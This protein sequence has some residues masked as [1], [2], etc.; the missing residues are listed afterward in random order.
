MTI[1]S[2]SRSFGAA[3]LGHEDG[4]AQPERDRQS[5]RQHRHAERADEQRQ[6]AVAHVGNARS[7]TT[8]C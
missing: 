7:G 5:H 8:P 4:R 1:F 2:V 6:R 3:E